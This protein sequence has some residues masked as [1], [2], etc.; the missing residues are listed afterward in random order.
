MGCKA[1]Q[2]AITVPVQTVEKITER[3]IPVEIPGDSTLFTALLYCDSLNEVRLL[4]ISELKSKRM[5]TELSLSGGELSYKAVTKPDTVYIP[6]T[7]IEINREV[8]V[9]V[10][11]PVVEYRQTDLQILSGWIGKLALIL[12][13]LWGV[14][15]LIQKKFKF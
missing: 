9:F 1:R 3:L 13:L 10:D 4:E 11:V 7:T 14:Y 12:A 2:A 15:K 6:G 8:P 5:Q